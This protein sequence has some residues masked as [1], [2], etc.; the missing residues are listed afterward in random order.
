MPQ[1]DMPQTDGTGSLLK[2]TSVYT[3]LATFQFCQYDLNPMR[4]VFLIPAI[5]RLDILP[6]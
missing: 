5:I 3:Y 4:T 1:T 6:K 2:L